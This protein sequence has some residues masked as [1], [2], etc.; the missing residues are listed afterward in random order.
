MLNSDLNRREFV[1]I[2]AGA[3]AALAMPAWGH[4]PL[5][6][7][8]KMVGIQIG[9]VS[10]VDEG[11]EKSAGYPSGTCR[12]KHAVP[13]GVH[14]RPRNRGKTD[15]RISSARSRQAGIRP[16]LSWRQLRHAS[17]PVLQEHGHQARRTRLITAISTSSRKYC[18]LPKNAA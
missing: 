15:S 14:L 5:V 3:G 11:T 10:F 13:R 1:K 2:T 18:L 12:R 9:A 8:S 16:Q 17:S 4:A 7:S 6:S